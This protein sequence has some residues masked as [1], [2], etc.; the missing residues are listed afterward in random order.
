[1]GHTATAPPDPQRTFE[2][3]RAQQQ[4]PR[5]ARPRPIVRQLAH[6]EARDR[7]ES[8]AAGSRDIVRDES[9]RRVRELLCAF[10]AELGV[11][12]T[13]QAVNFTAWLDQTG[14]RPAG[15]DLRCL[16]GLWSGL[17]KRGFIVAL[18]HQ[19]DGGNPCKAGGAHHS[20]TRPIFRI[21]ALPR[22]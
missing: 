12:A 10:L 14:Q 21:A 16:G 2:H 9:L 1:M 6:A 3:L 18:G 7:A 22:P 15:L 13:F 5:A 4:G 20:A 11:N 19:P 8:I 17:L